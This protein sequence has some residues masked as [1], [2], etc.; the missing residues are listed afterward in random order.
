MQE[1]GAIELP[2]KLEEEIFGNQKGFYF[3]NPEK[4]KITKNFTEEDLRMYLGTYFP[5]SYA[6]SYTIFSELLRIKPIAKAFEKKEKIKI[7]GIGSGTGGELVGA[8]EAFFECFPQN[9]AIFDLHV[10]DANPPALKMQKQI[11]DN[12]FPR[13][14]LW[15]KYLEDLKAETFFEQIQ[16]KV[17]DKKFDLILI[18]K[19]LNEI[20]RELENQKDKRRKFFKG[21]IR[22]GEY[23]LVNPHGLFILADITDPASH[24]GNNTEPE[25]FIPQIFNKFLRKRIGHK[26]CR[27]K[28][29]FPLSCA[30]WYY[31]CSQF[32][33]C[34]QSRTISVI[35]K[36][37]KEKPE[38]VDSSKITYRVLSCSQFAEEIL[39]EFPKNR[40][41]RLMESNKFGNTNYCER[42]YLRINLS[43]EAFPNPLDAWT[44]KDI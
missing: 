36:E 8:I 17:G 11:L 10:I 16:G 20:L 7:L 30:F 28:L 39:K 14:F 26:T 3:T 35:H 37:S 25:E 43:Q 4:V 15:T 29:I 42:G 19:M 1:K 40:P 13:K 5:R 2:K 31:V 24:Q 33:D 34:F 6:E 21:T 38:G 23:F 27:L 22:V 12:L 9:K 44:G 41:F 18:W 32:E